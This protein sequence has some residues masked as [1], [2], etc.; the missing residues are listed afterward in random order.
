MQ[1]R[2]CATLPGLGD[3]PGPLGGDELSHIWTEPL[4]GPQATEGLGREISHMPGSGPVREK[5]GTLSKAQ[6]LPSSSSSQRLPE[7][8][9]WPSGFRPCQA[10]RASTEG[11]EAV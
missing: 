8:V 4:Q 5:E 7:R 10:S 2:V 1:T 9:S 3:L 6:C 11:Q